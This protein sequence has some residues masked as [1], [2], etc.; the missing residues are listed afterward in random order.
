MW[1]LTV[2]QQI[3]L[4]KQYVSLNTQNVWAKLLHIQCFLYF[5]ILRCFRLSLVPMSRV[6]RCATKPHYTSSSLFR[7]CVVYIATRADL[8][9]KADKQ[10]R[11]QAVSCSFQI[12]IGFGR[13]QVLNSNQ[14]SSSIIAKPSQAA[15]SGSQISWAEISFI[16]TAQQPTHPSTHLPTRS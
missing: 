7:V 12:E 5:Y 6:F 3:F 16:I 4:F 8:F 9:A 2:F 10:I 13:P 11:G 15:T 1:V 14:T